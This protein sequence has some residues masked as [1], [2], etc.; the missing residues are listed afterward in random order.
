MEITFDLPD[1]LPDVFFRVLNVISFSWTLTKS[2]NG[3]LSLNIV[4]SP[5]PLK[6]LATGQR[7]EQPLPLAALSTGREN[8]HNGSVAESAGTRGVRSVSW[9]PRRTLSLLMTQRL[10]IRLSPA[11]WIVTHSFWTC[12]EAMDSSPKC[13]ESRRSEHS[14]H[15]CEEEGSIS[16][17]SGSNLDND[18]DVS[19][20]ACEMPDICATCNTGPPE[21]TQCKLINY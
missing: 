3:Q 13:Q 17:Q 1:I 21:V 9:E 4:H 7:T 18:D 11:M 19:D 15:T 8:L 16:A 14:V 2:R 5:S 6:H 20:D 12:P 10:L